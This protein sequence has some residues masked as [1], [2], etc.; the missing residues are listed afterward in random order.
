M[1][2]SG[3]TLLQLLVLTPHCESV[4]V[5]RYRNY[6]FCT[7]SGLSAGASTSTGRIQA[8]LDS[9]PLR[10]AVLKPYLHLEQGEGSLSKDHTYTHTINGSEVFT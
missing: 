7:V 8:S 3:A 5:D 9:F 2:K 10:P 1:E 6:D 4:D